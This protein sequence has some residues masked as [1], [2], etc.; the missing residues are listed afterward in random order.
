MKQGGFLVML[1]GVKH[2]ARVGRASPHDV[3]GERG[4][5]PYEEQIL[6]FAQDD[7]RV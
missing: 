1:N 3:F 5:S 2:L 6:R 7:R 4:R